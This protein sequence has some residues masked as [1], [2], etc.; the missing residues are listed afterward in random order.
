M[1]ILKYKEKVQHGTPDFPV[2]IYCAADPYEFRY[3]MVHHWHEECEIIRIKQGE[4]HACLNEKEFIAYAGDII[5]VNSGVLHSGL[6][7]NNCR[8]E[9]IVFKLSSFI[10]HNITCKKILL[11]FINQ[12]LVVYHHFKAENKI[13][14]DIIWKIFDDAQEQKPGYELTVSGGLYLFFSTVLQNHYYFQNSDLVS[15]YQ[16]LKK[17]EQLKNVLALI[18]NNYPNTI[19]LDDMAAAAH[20]SPK[21]FCRFFSNMTH[22]RPMDYLNRQRIE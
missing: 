9:C 10:K 12:T 16:N 8:Y 19:T 18:E 20:M 21:Y 22:Q 1:Q 13:I 6:P 7:Y 5:F 4:F 15:T 2:A 14:H 17:L 11:D 3:I